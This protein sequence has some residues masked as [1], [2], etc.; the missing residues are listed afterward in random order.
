MLS[1]GSFPSTAW[2]RYHLFGFSAGATFAL[3]AAMA[4]CGAVQSIALF[5]PATIGDDDWGPVEAQ[6][7]STLAD[8]GSLPVELRTNRVRPDDAAARA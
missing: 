3:A 4:F 1:P 2:A 7:R 5:E 8:V 6:W